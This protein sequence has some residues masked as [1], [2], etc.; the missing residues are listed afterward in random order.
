MLSFLP[1]FILLP[2]SI[3]FVILNTALVSFLIGIQALLKLLIPIAVINHYLTRGCNFIMYGWLCGNAL[4][5][6]LVN[7]VEWEVHDTTNLN[8]KGWHMVI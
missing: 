4:M 1:G 8:K 2:L 3:A 6:R 7:K 5:L